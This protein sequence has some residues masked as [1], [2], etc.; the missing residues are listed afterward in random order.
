MKILIANVGSSSLKCQLL[1]MPAETV[2]TKVLVEPSGR[3]MPPCSGSIARARR[4][5]SRRP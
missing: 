5:R 4:K 3:T 2:L 1:E